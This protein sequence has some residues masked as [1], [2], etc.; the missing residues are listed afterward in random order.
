MAAFGQIVISFHGTAQP[1]VEV[2]HWNPSKGYPRTATVKAQELV[3]HSKVS[4]A[5]VSTNPSWFQVLYV[6]REP[7][8]LIDV[9]LAPFGHRPCYYS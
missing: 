5:S 2:H 4:A 3:I 7:K 8:D 9:V 6:S 1:S